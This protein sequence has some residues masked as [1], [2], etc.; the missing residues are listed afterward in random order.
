MMQNISCVLKEPR[1]HL[2]WKEK[3]TRLWVELSGR[4]LISCAQGPPVHPLLEREGKRAADPRVGPFHS[5]PSTAYTCEVP[6]WTEALAQT[7]ALLPEE[8]SI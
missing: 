6:E 5:G 7:I 3:V 1:E 8:T 4:V 2:T